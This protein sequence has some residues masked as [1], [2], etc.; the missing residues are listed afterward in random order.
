MSETIWDRLQECVGQMP[1][2]FQALKIVGW[3]RCGY[4]D[5]KEQS[6]RAH[7]QAATSNACVESR[8]AFASRGVRARGSRQRG[9]ATWRWT[10]R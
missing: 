10:K 1:E 3:C 8:G 4:R 9:W 6:L 7:I 5:V 2:P